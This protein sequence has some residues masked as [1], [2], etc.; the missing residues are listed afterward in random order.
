MEP[1]RFGIVGCGGIAATHAECLQKLEAEGLCRLVAGAET[2]K[3]RRAAF[4]EKW[5]IAMHET[6]ADL[7]ARDDIDA[8]CVCTPSGLHGENVVQ[9]ARSGRHI[10]CEK[11][12]DVNLA[13]ADRAI[14]AAKDNGVVLSGIFQQRF[15]ADVMKVKRAVDAGAFGEIVFVHCETPWYRAQS[16]YDSGDWRG[17]WALDGGVLS[18]QAPHMIDRI[19]WLGGEIEDVVG[20]ACDAGRDRDIEA[21][22]L[23]AA[24]V[25][26]KNGAL[27]TITGTTLAYDGLDQRVL[28]CG[29]EGS[30]SFAGDRLVSFKTMRP[31]EEDETRDADTPDGTAPA[32]T[33]GTASAPL[34]LWSDNHKANIRDFIMALRE[35]REPL[36]KPAEMRRVVRVLNMIYAKAGVGPYAGQRF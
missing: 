7:L 16:Y 32:A 31:F 9:I 14:Q 33:Q 24:V 15:P 35:G 28:I 8:V 5:Q 23:G 29:T 34:A 19:M 12:L 11:P 21:E 25:R 30:A 26:L 6:L 22:T 27:G 10:L 13:N 1:T 18:N 2:D 20:A 4:G 3:G 17:T 36:V